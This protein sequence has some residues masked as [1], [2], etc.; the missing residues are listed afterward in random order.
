MPLKRDPFF[1]LFG[2]PTERRSWRGLGLLAFVYLGALVFAALLTP[3]VFWLVELWHKAAPSDTTAWLLRKGAD[4]Y[5]DRLRYVPVLLGLPWLLRACGLWSWRALGLRF[6]ARGF[7]S[8]ARWFGAG[9]CVVLAVAL[10]Q[11]FY[12]DVSFKPEIVGMYQDGALLAL[13]GKIL[14]LAINALLAG[15]ILGLLEELVFRGLIFRIFYTGAAPVLAI[16]LASAFFAYTHFKIPGAVWDKVPPGVSWD[17]GFFVAFWTLFGI[18][19]DF[20]PLQFLVLMAL[21][22][23]LTILTLRTRSLMPAIGLHAGLVFAMML[24]RGVSKF[25]EHPLRQLWGGG[26]LTDGWFPLLMILAIVAVL[27]ATPKASTHQPKP[28]KLSRGTLKTRGKK[29][30]TPLASR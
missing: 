28:L 30:R 18:T 14:G 12:T 26:G 1:I 16:V 5:F 7:K 23:A 8:L 4:V 25:G 15:L 19:H 29:D 9:C 21:G 24:N 10:P 27:I 6:D 17:T 20:H 2:L 13:A 3:P 11:V 22:S